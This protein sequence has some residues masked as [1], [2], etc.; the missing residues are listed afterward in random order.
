MEIYDLTIY[1]LRLR[2]DSEGEVVCLEDAAVAQA[3]GLT[4]GCELHEARG[5]GSRPVG[6]DSEGD[7]LFAKDAVAIA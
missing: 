2:L 3:A 6:I 5:V 1:N 4:A 7:A